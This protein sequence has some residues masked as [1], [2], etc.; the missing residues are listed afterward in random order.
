MIVH[1]GLRPFIDL[2]D[3]PPLPFHLVDP[4]RY[5][6]RVFGVERLSFSTSRGCPRNWAHFNYRNLPQEYP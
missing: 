2:N 1:N 3:L 6:M 4:P 5:L